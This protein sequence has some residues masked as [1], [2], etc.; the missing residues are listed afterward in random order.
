MVR[1]VLL[2]GSLLAG[3][4][5]AGVSA[6]RTP[7]D[8]FVA[9]VRIAGIDA[10]GKSV[11]ALMPALTE[12]AR[13]ASARRLEMRVAAEWVKRHWSPTRA[14]IG[15]AVDPEATAHR[16]LEV[17]RSENALVRLYSWFAGRPTVE[18]P[19]VW[20]TDAA[21][22]QAW[23]R[24]R[25]ATAVLRSAADARLVAD[26]SGFTIK[27][28]RNG[29]ALDIQAALTAISQRAPSMADDPLWLPTKPL[30][31][32]VTAADAGGIKSEVS[33]FRTRYSERGN[34]ATNLKVACSRIDGTILRPGATFSYNE[35][36]GPREAEAGFRMAPVIIRGK[37]EPGMG[38]GVCQVSTT[39][40]NAAVLADLKIV[41]RSHH[42]FPVHYVPAGR[43]ATV[44]YDSLDLKFQNNTQAPIAIAASA[45]DQQVRIRIFGQPVPGKVVRI[46]RRGVS[47]WEPHVETVS[48]PSLPAGRRETRDPGKS[49]H[50]ATVLRIV[51]ENGQETR[52]EVLSN[53]TYSS[54][55]RVV[56]VG[57]GPAAPPPAPAPAPGVRPP[58]PA[59][60]GASPRVR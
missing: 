1:V 11:T 17:G 54:F 37:L 50:R 58:Q 12:I 23:L 15:L 55:N 45:A 43:D 19:P 39:I 26:A 46:E 56:A 59:P 38:G 60:V 28:E 4:L 57:T 16:A 27:P 52:R 40:Y 3:V 24:K 20:K 49:G 22:L 13:G 31:A 35:V 30:T 33:S 32:R 34:R 21:K 10:G 51:T 25:V 48:D 53:D 41:Q 36:V 14:E 47:S 18:I 44:A 29:T 6:S 42:A 9:G 7:D 8:V 2:S 5:A